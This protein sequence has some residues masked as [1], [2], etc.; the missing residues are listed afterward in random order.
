MTVSPERQIKLNHLSLLAKALL[1]ANDELGAAQTYL[2]TLTRRIATSDDLEEDE[3]D[4]EEAVLVRWNASAVQE[5]KED[6]SLRNLRLFAL[7][8]S[9]HLQTWSNNFVPA[10]L[11]RVGDIGYVPSTSDVGENSDTEVYTASYGGFQ[12]FVRICNI[13]DSEDGHNCDDFEVDEDT[14][15]SM[16]S[17][18]SARFSRTDLEGFEIGG[19]VFGFVVTLLL[20]MSRCS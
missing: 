6:V 19:G 1:P 7:K 13:L 5:P 11:F 12:R 16:T 18:Q 4:D 9:R 8:N 10:F 2:G 20:P 15:G 14:S 3:D 17:F